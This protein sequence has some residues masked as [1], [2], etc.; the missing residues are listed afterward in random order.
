MKLEKACKIALSCGLT[1]IGE[2]VLNIK[3]HANSMFDYHLW[4][5]EIAELENEYIECLQEHSDTSENLKIS[6]VFPRI[7]HLHYVV[8]DATCPKTGGNKL[9]AHVC[10][11][12][13]GWGAGFILALSAKWTQPEEEY[14][15]AF[16]SG[17]FHS[18]GDIQVCNTDDPEITV[19]NM[20]AQNGFRSEENSVP[21]SYEALNICM[22]K[23]SCFADSVK[24]SIHMPRIGCGLA[25]GDREKVEAIIQSELC[26]KGIDVFV[27]DLPHFHG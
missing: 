14:R 17:Q 4:N 20:I 5:E 10:N 12:K 24:A 26:D 21:L 23:L 3:L 16:Q 18:L 13:G 8:G 27:Y 1:T 7:V 9:V 15:R 11:N 25:G 22:K 19:V 2:A 6:D